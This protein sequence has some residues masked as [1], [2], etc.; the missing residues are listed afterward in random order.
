[1]IFF[2][3]SLYR[4]PLFIFIDYESRQTFVAFSLQNAKTSKSYT[5]TVLLFLS[6]RVCVFM[7]NMFCILFTQNISNRSL[8]IFK[9]F[10]VVQMDLKETCL[11]HSIP[12]KL[13]NRDFYYTLFFIL[14]A[15]LHPSVHS[16][17]SQH[18]CALLRVCACTPSITTRHS[19][20]RSGLKRT[21]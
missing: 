4:Y 20:G 5:T 12:E 17:V 14:V 13:W 11:F 21:S 18:A 10:K 7:L 2:R 16:T 9:D 6:I 3:R 15:L 19:W 1:M 8:I